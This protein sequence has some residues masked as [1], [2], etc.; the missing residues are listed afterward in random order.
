M[1]KQVGVATGAFV[2]ILGHRLLRLADTARL[3]GRVR[4]L[5]NRCSNI[6][7]TAL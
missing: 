4:P 1:T 3:R 7:A 6:G 2:V 5:I